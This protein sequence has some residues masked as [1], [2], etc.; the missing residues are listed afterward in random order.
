MLLV[1]VM[2]VDVGVD[3]CYWYCYRI[4]D[5]LFDFLVYIVYVIVIVVVIVDVIALGLQ[6]KAQTEKIFH[7]ICPCKGDF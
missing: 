7:N 2:A 5:L 3:D 4:G 6:D 1:V